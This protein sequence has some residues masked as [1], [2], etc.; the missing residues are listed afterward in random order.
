[1]KWGGASDIPVLGDFD[2]DGKTDI[3]IFRP[4]DGGWYIVMSSTGQGVLVKWGGAC[5]IPVPG[6]LRRRR[7]NRHGGLPPVRWQLVHVFRRPPERSMS[8]V[9]GCRLGHSDPRPI[10]PIDGYT[11]QLCADAKLGLI[12]SCRSIGS[13]AVP[14]SATD[15]EPNNP[16]NVG[17]IDRD[18]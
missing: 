8:L 15:S 7:K 2:G 11:L 13:P 9:W 16:T 3:A 14:S 6:G 4:S 1:M 18:G 12:R 5:D 17:S 10:G